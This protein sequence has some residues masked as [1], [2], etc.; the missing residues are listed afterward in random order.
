MLLKRIQYN[1]SEKRL[2]IVAG[3][4]QQDVSMFVKITTM[5]YDQSTQ[6][7]LLKTAGNCE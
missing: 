4:S 1:N 2:P 6:V 5:R 3:S 7:I